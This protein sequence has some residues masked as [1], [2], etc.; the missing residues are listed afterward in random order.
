MQEQYKDFSGTENHER[1]CLT[2]D[3]ESLN[4]V[5]TFLSNKG[6]IETLVDE[7]GDISFNIPKNSEINVKS[8]NIPE[9]MMGK[10]VEIDKEKAT[11]D[12]DS[13]R[14]YALEHNRDM[15]LFSVDLTKT[16]L[17]EI[18]EEEDESKEDNES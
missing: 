3:R 8:I 7:I 17:N 12:V 4:E 9:I 13:D 11:L 16:I 14:F 2:L 15:I 10:L 6:K 5:L 18:R 1:Y